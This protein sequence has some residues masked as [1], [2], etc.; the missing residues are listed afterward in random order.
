L[1]TFDAVEAEKYIILVKSYYGTEVT[2]TLSFDCDQTSLEPSKEPS[3]SLQP[4]NS[5]EPSKEPSGEP[6]SVPSLSVSP[7]ES[8]TQELRCSDTV[9]A[10]TVNCPPVGDTEC[11]G[12]L[13]GGVW[14]YS[15]SGVDA[16]VTVSTCGGRCANWN[17]M[18]TVMLDTVIEVFQESV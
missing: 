6:S 10:S 2:F 5:A 17:S 4:S 12:V 7:S 9:E 1:Y 13:N 16:R 18:D 14:L 11:E 3:T 15:I 8:C